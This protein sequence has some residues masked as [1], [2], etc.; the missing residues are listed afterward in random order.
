MKIYIILLT[1][2]FLTAC[3]EQEKSWNMD[4]S[5]QIA[6]NVILESDMYTENDGYNFKET[7]AEFLE[8]KDCY[9]FSYYYNID[10][11]SGYNVN[12][13]MQKDR[14]VDTNYVKSSTL[15]PIEDRFDEFCENKCGDGF[16]NEIVCQSVDCPC[17]EN[18]E[19]CPEDC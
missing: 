1:L 16:C 19:N 13:T 6:V 10:V 14:V 8:C 15:I 4:D 11:D 12:I 3:S 7:N 9:I 5:R 17:E 18:K 2:L